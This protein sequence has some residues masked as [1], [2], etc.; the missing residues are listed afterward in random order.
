MKKGLLV[1]SLMLLMMFLVAFDVFP[2]FDLDAQPEQMNI[3]TEVVVDVPAEATASADDDT[4]ESVYANLHKERTDDGAFII[5][6]PSAPVTIIVFEDFL[7]GHCQRYRPI[8][9]DILV[10]YVANGKARLEFRM[11]P[12]IDRQYSPLLMKT[13]ECA[14]V[15]SPGLF[16]EAHDIL[17]DAATDGNLTLEIGTYVAEMLSLDA[18]AMAACIET[19]EQYQIDGRYGQSLGVTGTPSLRVSVNGSAPDI[20]SYDGTPLEGGAVPYEVIAALLDGDPRAEVGFVLL[21]DN[22]LDDTSL[23]T[24]DPCEIPCWQGITMGE[25]TWEAALEVVEGN[26]RYVIID[27]AE[28]PTTGAARVIWQDGDDNPACCQL[29]TTNGEFAD[30]LV[31]QLAPKMTLGEI[32]EVIGEPTLLTGEIIGPE[33]AVISLIYPEVGLIIQAFVAGESGQ[34]DAQNPIIGALLLSPSLM[35]Q[36]L[37]RGD[38]QFWQGYQSF[39]D[40]FA[41]DA[42]SAP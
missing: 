40:Y 32:S 10:N 36:V 42:D 25:T 1:S 18:D 38:F 33:K 34:I 29:F 12:V 26:E 27:R 28:D 39:A 13:A 19:A 2:F 31:L 7:C 16:W 20:I 22:M 21:R 14:D 4:T 11:F 17:F 9:H 6:E 5:G 41:T 35:E 15:L 24:S 23:A 30:S 3:N 8:M 37:G